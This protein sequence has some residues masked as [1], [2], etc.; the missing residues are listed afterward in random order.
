MAW[1]RFGN[2]SA[3]CWTA[4]RGRQ[5]GWWAEGMAH[6]V[7]SNSMM[8]SLDGGGRRCIDQVTQNVPLPEAYRKATGKWDKRENGEVCG[9]SVGKCWTTECNIPEEGAF[10]VAVG[11]GFTGKVWASVLSRCGRLKGLATPLRE[12]C[13]WDGYGEIRWGAQY[14]VALWERGRGGHWV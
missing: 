6:S 12:L 10:A 2:V 11:V 5:R 9:N 8:P 4:E 13:Q 3:A 14:K 1:T 7:A